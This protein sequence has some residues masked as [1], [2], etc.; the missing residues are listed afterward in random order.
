MRI[1][2]A[3]T[4]RLYDAGLTLPRTLD[5]PAGAQVDDALAAL[6]SKSGSARPLAPLALLAISGVHIGTV[7]H[8]EPRTL[9]ED[10]EVLIFSPVAGG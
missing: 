3:V 4:G 1:T 2:L 5:L 7:A 6:K 8:H 10:D 9:V